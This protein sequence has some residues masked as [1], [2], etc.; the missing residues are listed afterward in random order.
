MEKIVAQ[1]QRLA[2]GLRGKRS[3]NEADLG[4]MI[5]SRLKNAMMVSKYD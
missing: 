3:T 2:A 4:E 5:P 1:W